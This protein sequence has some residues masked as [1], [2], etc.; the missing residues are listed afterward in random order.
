MRAEDL[1]LPDASAAAKPLLFDLL[2]LTLDHY[3]QAADYT[4]AIPAR[5]VRLRLACLWPIL[6]GLETLVLLARNDAW[7][8]PAHP[9]KVGR[10][11]VYSIMA[12]SIPVIGSNTVVRM[13]IERLIAKVEAQ[14]TR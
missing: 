3:R 5:C 6:F 12:R 4:L 8:D 7:L 9:S 1:L 10:N 11:Q 14:L 13:W 2:R